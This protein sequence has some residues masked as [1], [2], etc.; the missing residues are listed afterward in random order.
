MRGVLNCAGD[1]I[2]K[3][4]YSKNLLNK[5]PKQNHLPTTNWIQSLPYT[6]IS[7]GYIL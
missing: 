3:I 7:H 2:G 1:P 4:N 5:Q 6:F